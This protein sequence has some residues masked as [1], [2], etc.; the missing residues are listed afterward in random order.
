MDQ[1]II[2][3]LDWIVS[4]FILMHLLLISVQ[5]KPLDLWI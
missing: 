4:Y 5:A 3:V 1:L 2:C